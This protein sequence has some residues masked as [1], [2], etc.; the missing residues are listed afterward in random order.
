MVLKFAFSQSYIRINLIKII[1]M[2][3]NFVL[4]V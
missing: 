2:N 1:I 4:K 3:P